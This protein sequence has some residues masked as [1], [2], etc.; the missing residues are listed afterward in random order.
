MPLHHHFKDKH[1]I[2]IRFN[3]NRESKIKSSDNYNNI[4]GLNQARRN[5]KHLLPLRRNYKIVCSFSC[6]YYWEQWR[7][8]IQLEHKISRL[9]LKNV[10]E[11]P[12]LWMQKAQFCWHL[13]PLFHYIAIRN[14]RHILCFSQATPWISNITCCCLHRVE[15]FEVTGG[16][17]FCWYYWNC[18]PSLSF[19]KIVKVDKKIIV[20]QKHW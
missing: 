11:Q 1:I 8:V 12:E 4:V 19:F 18:W 5:F 10:I 13:F 20:R 17:S 7:I 6:Q 15:W 3:K 2:T 9:L 16:C 14:V